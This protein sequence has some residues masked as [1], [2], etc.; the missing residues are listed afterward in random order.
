MNPQQA[1]YIL[2]AQANVWSE[3]IEDGK[4]VEYMVFPRT[5]ALSEVLWGTSN[6][7]KYD[8]FKSRLVQQLPT[9]DKKGINYSKAFLNQT[10]IKE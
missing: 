3:Y 9:L 2:G 1:K 6:P 7:A 8:D 10:P 5:L 4:K